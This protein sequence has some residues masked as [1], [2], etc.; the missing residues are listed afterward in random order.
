MSVE[1][2]A[3]MAGTVFFA[4][5]VQGVTGLGFALISVAIIALLVGP[6]LAVI[7]ITAATAF[8]ALQQVVHFLPHRSVLPRIAPVAVGALIGAVIGTQLL[9]VLPAALLSLA[10]GGL[11]AWYVASSF[12]REAL[13]IS[14]HH[15]RKAAPW[16]GL[17]A[18][19]SNGGLGASGPILA[20]Y[21][22]SL[23]LRPAEFMLS[24]ASIFCVL[25]ASRAAML[26]AL[27]QFTLHNLIISLALCI[28]ALAGQRLGHFV[29]GQISALV[30]RRVTLIVLG[31]AAASL[32]GRGIALTAQ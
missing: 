21:L 14:E 11:T 27:S 12:W 15:E 4:A 13:L 8:L 30:F 6:K 25:A 16:V 32:L 19:I 5:I 3:A 20:S 23:G 9:V 7:F 18:G 10:L 2:F 1:L 26:A 31:V 24:I 17:A 29:H 22:N 28:P